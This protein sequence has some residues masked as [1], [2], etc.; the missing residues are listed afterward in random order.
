LDKNDRFAKSPFA[1]GLFGLSAN[2]YASAP[3]IASQLYV[4][5]TYSYVRLIP[6]HTLSLASGAFCFAIAMER[7]CEFINNKAPQN[8]NGVYALDYHG[9]M[10]FRGEVSD[11]VFIRSNYLEFGG[12]DFPFTLSAISGRGPAQPVAGNHP[13]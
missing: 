5:A 6:R 10:V 11:T 4:T 8:A 7:I 9:S 12:I 1:T 13:A 2:S 3:I